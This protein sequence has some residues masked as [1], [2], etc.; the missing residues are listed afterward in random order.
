[1]SSTEL[2]GQLL[3]PL[4]MTLAYTATASASCDPPERAFLLGKA[5]NGL[6]AMAELLHTTLGFTPIEERD[7]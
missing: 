3:R 6:E 4:W 1:M 2:A 7:P 5:I